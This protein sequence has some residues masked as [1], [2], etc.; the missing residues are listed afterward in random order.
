MDYTNDDT[1]IRLLSGEELDL[2]NGG[3]IVK[4][5]ANDV[6]GVAGAVLDTA[7]NIILTTIKEGPRHTC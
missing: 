3:N 2:V 4:T 1:A 7:A 6:L 5:V